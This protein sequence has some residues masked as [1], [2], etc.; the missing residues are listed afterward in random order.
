MQSFGAR[1]PKVTFWCVDTISG[2]KQKQQGEKKKETLNSH[3]CVRVDTAYQRP[4][5]KKKSGF[6]KKR[7]LILTWV[8]QS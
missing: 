8:C 3:A 2:Q 4:K 6:K 1:V 7:D 5:T